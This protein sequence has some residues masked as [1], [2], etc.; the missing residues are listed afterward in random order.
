MVLLSSLLPLLLLLWSRVQY[1]GACLR[2]TCC[3]LLL[4]L[5]KSELLLLL[6]L[7]MPY[8]AYKHC[9][10]DAPAMSS[11]T[12]KNT[13]IARYHPRPTKMGWYSGTL[14]RGK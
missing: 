2:V 7:V 5:L 4:L 9:R 14:P 13:P 3:E 8:S 1:L 10:Y 11:G 12:K 6:S